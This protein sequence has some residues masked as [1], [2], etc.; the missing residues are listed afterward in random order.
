MRRAPAAT[1]SKRPLVEG[2][3][4]RDF[5]NGIKL[6]AGGAALGA[7]SPMRAFASGPG[8]VYS[9]GSVDP[10]MLRSGNRPSTYNVAHWMRDGRLTFT[11][12]TVT[13]AATS[14]D[15]SA[16][17]FPIE[18]D[19]GTYDVVI[20]GTGMAG[21]STAHFLLEDRPTLK[22]LMLEGNPVPG[23][24]GASDEDEALPFPAGTAGAYAVM[25]YAD[26]LVDLYAGINVDWESY[27]IPAP[28]YAYF[29]DDYA[30]NVSPGTNGWYND[31]YG[32]GLKDLPYSA[33]IIKDLKSA[34]T[35]FQQWYMTQGSPTDPADQSDPRYDWL[36]QITL[37]Q[38]LVQTKGFSQAVADFYTAYA[39]DALAGQSHQVNAYT[40]VSF[41]GAEYFDAFALPGANGGLMRHF[42]KRLV[43]GSIAGDES[44][45]I[46]F[47]PLRP[48]N[49]DLSTNKVR[50]RTSSVALRADSDASG[51]DVVYYRDGT[52]YRAHA[53]SVVIATN[54]H[55]AQHLV[56]HLAG[57]AQLAA[58]D[59]MMT[60]P[61][62][63]ANV[64]LRSAAPIVN[65][66]NS[67]DLY[68]WGSQYWAD[69][70]VN[71]WSYGDRENPDRPVTLT[72]YGGNWSDPEDMP[73]ER[74]KLL[75]T[76]FSS[77]E[78]SL[79]DDLERVFAGEGFDF[80]RDVTDVAVY[81]WGHGMTYPKV[82]VPHGAPIGSGKNTVRTPAPRHAAR[83]AIGRISIAGQDTE[84]SPALESA[85]GSGL[86]VSQEVLTR[87]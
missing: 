65:S 78:S 86:R 68:W 12:T 13:L 72:F 6:A 16:G 8:P 5:L 49:Y 67:Y 17:T 21:L 23:G 18:E 4:R 3:R 14:R 7:F 35:D 25:P 76:P 29:F 75:T 9:D 47:N 26:F 85:F 27:I 43:P 79:A 10:R 53:S 51:A 69:A 74:V 83:A 33:E 63:T 24:N 52:F 70:V 11:T 42:L 39:I 2:I 62:V 44:D 73:A 32:K 46:L 22:I 31:V 38:Y 58:F 81:R 45:D 82:G 50:V 71:D 80:A 84:S 87:L 34:R 57:T 30:P 15:P 1:G 41:L 61:V 28:G 40:S 77:Y 55:S 59:E 54:A 60:V 20:V 19:T 66:A 48:E 36:A 37:E 64:T 56:K